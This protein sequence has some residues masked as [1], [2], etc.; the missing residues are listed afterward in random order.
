[1]RLFMVRAKARARSKLERLRT[2][3]AAVMREAE[4]A[5][6]LKEA[7]FNYTKNHT[8]RFS[9]AAISCR[10]RIGDYFG[11]RGSGGYSSIQVSHARDICARKSFMRLASKR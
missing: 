5:D 1:M 7:R 10:L 9:C 8:K 3:D 2:G 6:S 11:A 4:A